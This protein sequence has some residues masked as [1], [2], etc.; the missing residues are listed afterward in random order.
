MFIMPDLEFQ[1]TNTTCLPFAAFIVPNIHQCQ[2]DCLAQ[3]QCQAATFHRP[4]AYC[5]LFNNSPDPNNPMVANIGTTTM[6]V[7]TRTRFPTG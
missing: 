3:I 7:T 5:E 1:C 4:S 2:I 6:I